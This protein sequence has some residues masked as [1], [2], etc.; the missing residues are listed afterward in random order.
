MLFQ[1]RNCIANMTNYVRTQEVLVDKDV[2]Q[3]DGEFEC[4]IQHNLKK[5]LSHVEDLMTIRDW[6]RCDQLP[7]MYM[8]PEHT[9]ISDK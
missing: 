3:E 4:R 5:I 8:H 2:E 1:I 7:N 9:D 6:V